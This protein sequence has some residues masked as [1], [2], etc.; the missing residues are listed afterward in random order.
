MELAADHEGM[1]RD[2]HDLDQATIWAE[3]AE[4][5]ACGYELLAIL[6]VEFEAVAVALVNLFLPVGSRGDGAGLQGARIHTEPHRPAQAGDVVLVWHE[7]DDRVLGGP[8][9]LGA[10][11]VVQAKHVTRKLD[12]H[13]LHAEAQAEVRGLA[14]A[15]EL[16]SVNLALDPAIAESARHDD[17]VHALQ[18]VLVLALL[19]LAG[20]DPL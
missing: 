3:A 17:A 12:A 14:H 19:Q 10:V 18:H 11:G 20:V 8:V 2:L 13:Y 16:R 1:V 15:G 9:E 4:A 5:R 6:V 7:V